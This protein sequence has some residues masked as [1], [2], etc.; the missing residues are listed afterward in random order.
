MELGGGNSGLFKRMT[1]LFKLGL[2]AMSQ[3][4][5]GRMVVN[6]TTILVGVFKG[7]M[8]GLDG[9]LRERDIPARNGIQVSFGRDLQHGV[10]RG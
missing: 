6:R 3:V 5:V 1:Q 8:A 7:G 10:L 2:V 4:D 9:L